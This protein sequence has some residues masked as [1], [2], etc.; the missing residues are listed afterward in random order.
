MWKLF[1]REVCTFAC[2]PRV[3]INRLCKSALFKFALS[4]KRNKRGVSSVMN[5]QSFITELQES[6]KRA[7]RNLNSSKKGKAPQIEV[8]PVKA[9]FYT[10]TYVTLKFHLNF[11]LKHY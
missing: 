6:S 8:A 9:G 10:K 5:E 2:K 11:S 3:D 1:E 4:L 7:P